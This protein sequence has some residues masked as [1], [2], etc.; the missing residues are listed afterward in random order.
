MTLNT[1]SSRL[2]V[3]ARLTVADNRALL[4]ESFTVRGAK[5]S[6]AKNLQII[7]SENGSLAEVEINKPV[8]IS[9]ENLENRDLHIG[10]LIFSPDGDIDILFPLS[11]GK[12][13]ALVLAGQTV[14]IPS[15]GKLSFGKPLGIVEV[16]IV[17]STA[18]IDKALKPLQTLV[19]EQK[20]EKRSSGQVA[21]KAEEAIASLL[22]DLAGGKRGETKTDIRL[23]DTQQTLP[24]GIKSYQ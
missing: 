4:A 9:V 5:I 24:L 19:M 17:A 13:A 6:S 11:D 23:F 1:N 21:E 10:V 14:Q 12:N 3:A 8:Q 7:S 20:S 18:P 15:E 2:K 22:D 16:L